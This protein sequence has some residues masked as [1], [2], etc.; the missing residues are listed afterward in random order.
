MLA[1]LLSL[2]LVLPSIPVIAIE[3]NLETPQNA[4]LVAGRALLF[5]L[6]EESDF[7]DRQNEFEVL[8]NGEPVG[9]VFMPWIEEGLNTIVLDEAP[10]ADDEVVLVVLATGQQVNV[11]FELEEEEYEPQRDVSA[12]TVANAAAFSQAHYER[13]GALNSNVRFGLEVVLEDPVQRAKLA[14]KNVALLTN[15]VFVDARMNSAILGFA[16]AT[17]FTLVSMFA[18][19]H[20]VR[21]EHQAGAP[22]P[23]EIDVETGVLVWSLYGNPMPASP[24]ANMFRT[25]TTNMIGNVPSGLIPGG[26]KHEGAL[27]DIILYD[28]PS[29]GSVTWTYLFDLADVMKSIVEFE[30]FFDVNGNPKDQGSPEEPRLTYDELRA[31]PGHQIQLIVLDRPNPLGGLVVEGPIRDMRPTAQGG[32]GTGGFWRFPMPSRYGMT[33]GE[34]AQMFVGEWEHNWAVTRNATLNPWGGASQTRSFEHVNMDI[35]PVQGWTRNMLWGDWDPTGSRFIMPSPNMPTWQAAFAYTGT[36]W[37]E[38]T[39]VGE[40]GTTPVWTLI[41]APYMR[42]VEL[43]E[44]L[45]RF[46][47]EHG[48]L[49]GVRYRAAGN[50]PINASSQA[51]NFPGRLSDGVEIHI[52]DG[53]RYRPIDCVLIHTLVLRTMYGNAANV[54]PGAALDS[55]VIANGVNFSNN[56]NS[57]VGN[58]IIRDRLIAFPLGASDAEIIA[59][60]NILKDIIYYGDVPTGTPGLNDE[61]LANRLLYLLPEYGSP[62]PAAWVTPSTPLPTVVMGYEN[63]L[64]SHMDRLDGQRVGLVANHTAIDPSPFSLGHVVDILHADSNIN[65][66][67]L[68]APAPGLRAL[69]Q[70]AEMTNMWTINER[71]SFPGGTTYIDEPTGLPVHRL[72]GAHTVPTAAQL[73]NVDV[74]LFDMQDS[75]VRF[76]SHIGLLADVMQAAA[77]HDVEL[78][79]LD[80]PSMVATATVDG[81]VSEADFGYAVP[82]R[83]GMTIGELALLLKN[84]LGHINGGVTAFED[85]NLTV[86]PMTGFSPA[87][88]PK[89]MNLQFVAPYGGA[90]LTNSAGHISPIFIGSHHAALAYSAI[91]MIESAQ[92]FDGRGTT[93]SF[94]AI[95]APFVQPQLV[96]LQAAMGALNLPGVGFRTIVHVPWNR[97]ELTE[98]GGLF[99]GQP[100]FGLQ[101]HIYD[102]EA[103]NSTETIIALLVTMR[104]L[105]P[106]SIT[107][108]TFPAEFNETVGNTWLAPMILGGSSVAEIMSE[109]QAALDDFMVM[110]ARNTIYTSTTPENLQN[111]MIAS[112]VLPANTILNNNDMRIRVAADSETV[113]L[114]FIPVDIPPSPQM[115]FTWEVFGNSALTGTVLTQGGRGLSGHAI[116]SLTLVD[117]TNRFWIRTTYLQNDMATPVSKV[118]E[119][120]IT[121]NLSGGGPDLTQLGFSNSEI[122]ETVAL[123]FYDFTREGSSNFYPWVNALTGWNGPGHVVY[124]ASSNHVALVD[125]NLNIVTSN[126][127]G[128]IM[129][130]LSHAGVTITATI[131]AD[132]SED[133]FHLQSI[134]YTVQVRAGAPATGHTMNANEGFTWGTFTHP[135]VGEQAFS[136]AFSLTEPNSFVPHPGRGAIPGDANVVFPYTPYQNERPL[137]TFGQTWDGTAYGGANNINNAT[138]V[139]WFRETSLGA[140]EVLPQGHVFTEDAVYIAEMFLT[141]AMTSGNNTW[142]NLPAGASF[143]TFINNSRRLPVAGANGI[144]NFNIVRAANHNMTI[145]ITFAPLNDNGG[146]LPEPVFPPQGTPAREAA[147]LIVEQMTFDEMM[148]QLIFPRGPGQITPTAQTLATIENNHFGGVTLFA[149]DVGGTIDQMVNLTY[150][151]QQAAIRGSRFNIP[152][153]IS[154]DNE[155]GNVFR[156]G[157]GSSTAFLGTTMPGNMALGAANDL[158]LTF[159][160]GEVLGREVLA[161]GSNMNLAPTVDVNSNPANPVIGVR[162]PGSDPERVAGIGA[163]LVEGMQSIPGVIATAKHFPGHGNTDVDSHIA[164]PLVP[165]NLAHLR[166][167]DLVPFRAAVDAGVGMIMTAHVTVPEADTAMMTGTRTGATF[168]RVA[169]LSPLFL[170]DI[171]RDEW[172]Y[173]G[174]IIADALDMSAV[175]DHFYAIDGVYYSIMAGV[176]IP[177]IPLRRQAAGGDHL[178]LPGEVVTFNSGHYIVLTNQLRARAEANPEFMA[179]VVE[180]A[181][182]V[183]ESKI[184]FGIYEP[185]AGENQ[186]PV[187]NSLADQQVHANTTIRRA[188]HLAVEREASNAAITLAVNESF[189]G[190]P[191]LPFSLEDGHSVFILTTSNAEGRVETLEAAVRFVAQELGVTVTVTSAT[192]ADANGFTAAHRTAISNA[193]FVI[194]GSAITGGAFRLPTNP[195]AQ[196]LMSIWDFIEDEGYGYK[197]VNLALALP[198]ELSFLQNASALIHTNARANNNIAHPDRLVAM[199]SAV[200]GNFPVPIY[201]SAVEAVFGV[202]SPTGTFPVD[203]RDEHS[204]DPENIFVR[205]VGDGLRFGAV[206]TATVAVGTQI[207]TLMAGTAGTVTFPVTT[208]NIADGTYNVTVATLPTGVTVQGQVTIANNSGTLTLSATNAIVEGTHSLHLTIGGAT[209]ATPF[210]LTI[211]EATQMPIFSFNIFNNGPG[212]TPSAFNAGLANLGIIRMWTRLDG[213]NAL[214]PYADLEITAT[215]PNG[216][217]AMEFIRINRIWNDLDNV[218]LIDANKNAPWQRIYLTAELFGQTVEVVLV[219]DLYVAQIFGLHAF[220]NGNDNNAS[221]AQAGV[222]RIWTQLNGA[223]AMVPY[224][225]LE[226]DARLPDGTC[227]MEFIRVNQPWANPG[228]VN[229]I[230]ANKH[231][232][233]HTIYLTATLNGQ[234]VEL[235]LIN[236]RFLGLHA[237]NNGTDEQVPGLAGTIRIWSMLGGAYAPIPMNAVITA[238]DQDDNDALEF[239]TKNRQWTDAGWRDYNVNF[240][241]T[242]DAHWETITF[243]VTVYGQTVTLLLI[244]DWFSAAPAPIL[245]LVAFNNG[246]DEQVPGLAGTIRIWPELD[247]VGTPL[248]MSAVI[249]AVDQDNNDAMQFVARNRQW[250]DAGWQDYY[251]N[252]DV[253]KNAPWQ[254]IYF[255]VSAFGQTVELTLINNLYAPVP[256]EVME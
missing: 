187:R 4:R 116:G 186:P 41:H 229:L 37:H 232:P 110:R 44:R 111:G 235:T 253:N 136:V 124:T 32:I 225:D 117:G 221:L 126:Q 91:G 166:D 218:N 5:E 249:T 79:V 149:P 202:L 156:Y 75:G 206:E 83:H 108:A 172:G 14:G 55:F 70:D 125:G 140:R 21:G 245:S 190:T 115:D 72:H 50:T 11:I 163:A 165:G 141:S 236:N 31:I 228:Y 183:V 23:N 92:L 210:T 171:L 170:T 94:E 179:R 241:V 196:T 212:G 130:H 28:L 10:D 2:C 90:D 224:A 247:G 114:D 227:A 234:S 182:R 19:E 87:L 48:I 61:F 18:Q 242:K 119:L 180:S 97:A 51:Q 209:T 121:A 6:G 213:V 201:L 22:V 98:H 27:I 144:R 12:A 132:D 62:D 184:V 53:Q 197:A 81:P 15:Q 29:I 106:A 214:V 113:S 133:P 45:N 164:L 80:R 219:N 34:L 112:V 134:S 150:S 123:T 239:V 78:I 146:G 131:H 200:T 13:V 191:V 107:A 1:F 38:G 216:Q 77:E 104:Q 153:A 250:T 54:S 148:G 217:C 147:T 185:W 222:I 64:T 103:F 24:T 205:R 139:A 207:G 33:F 60:F 159:R 102:F 3:F 65:L 122:G 162:S 137:F 203:V 39:N 25:I 223:N 154:I 68:F 46:V 89:D 88:Y 189:N 157:P 199:N 248:P 208:V 198:Y 17:D 152:L 118:Y 76:N 105:F 188:D 193:D 174:L 167:N 220:N 175:S 63:L 243:S 59:E 86:I 120:I 160:V 47:D 43:A 181:I 233:W 135:A 204:A 20:G 93:R 158:D 252:I 67:T 7:L 143:D 36:V 69:R 192:Y 26:Y 49:E 52:V 58:N 237:Y 226:V 240:D 66:T 96:E 142:L 16:E 177:L 230:D 129:P 109:Y 195:R 128:A 254:T 30:L 178:G 85:L 74:L 155:G 238:V 127:T 42:G 95:G 169:T 255:T 138:R 246:T 161:G 145:T 82:V 176:D 231:A 168:S 211:S 73:A 151:M 251:V 9:F 173:E 215:L 100:T 8:V 256:L 57:R 71:G 40:R 35:I 99:A 244:N 84:D 101:L 194:V 56:M